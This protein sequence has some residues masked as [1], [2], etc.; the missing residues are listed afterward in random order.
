MTI[1]LCTIN[2]SQDVT[3]E[4]TWWKHWILHNIHTIQTYKKHKKYSITIHYVLH[5]ITGMGRVIQSEIVGKWDLCGYPHFYQIWGYDWWKDMEQPCIWA[6]LVL[7]FCTRSSQ[8]AR[9]QLTMQNNS[10]HFSLSHWQP[11]FYNHPQE[12]TAY[13]LQSFT[14]RL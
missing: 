5:R 10:Q 6:L 14:C 3:K 13:E 11:R 12:S 7:R 2:N 4:Q 8:S 9:I 1:Y